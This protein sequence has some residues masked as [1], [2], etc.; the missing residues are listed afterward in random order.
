MSG[1]VL[2]DDFSEVL[3]VPIDQ[4]STLS[5]S[6][7]PADDHP[8]SPESEHRWAQLC[9]HNPALLNG[10]ILA[11][12]AWHAQQQRL[13][14]R[15]AHYQQMVA[16]DPGRS[17]IVQ[18]GVTGVILARNTHASDDEPHVLLAQRT[19]RTT[20]YPGQWELAP[21]GGINPPPHTPITLNLSA[22]LDALNRESHEELG[23]DLTQ[24]TIRTP[25][26]CFD[27]FAPSA[28][29][30]CIV[31]LAAQCDDV[32]RSVTSHL[33]STWEYTASQWIPVSRLAQAADDPATTIIPP[34][35]AIMRALARD[36]S[37]LKS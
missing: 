9:A 37:L 23:L 31:H 17:R 3:I 16:P 11:L 2:P 5:L 28:D 21:S 14:A 10:P 27:P 22:W 19:H 15:V 8:A 4:P 35:R 7:L 13:T 24:S 26:L 12:D 30:V 32:D 33:A 18:I 36:H 1:I 34:S 20:V 6:V 29:L 25:M